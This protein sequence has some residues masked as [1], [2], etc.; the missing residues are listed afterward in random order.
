[1]DHGLLQTDFESPTWMRFIA[2]QE[3]KLT[4]LRAKNDGRMDEIET[5]RLRGRIL[6]VKLILGLTFDA[7]P[8]SESNDA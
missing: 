8:P 1:M 7:P 6:E 3:K 4:E 2:Y 5:A